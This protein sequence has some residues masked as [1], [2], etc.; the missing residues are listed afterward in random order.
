MTGCHNHRL[1]PV[2]EPAAIDRTGAADLLPSEVG[3]LLDRYHDCWKVIIVVDK[4]NSLTA[5]PDR[6]P[7]ET[8]QIDTSWADHLVTPMPGVPQR[9]L[10]EY[11]AHGGRRCLGDRDMPRGLYRFIRRNLTQGVMVFNSGATC[12]AP[13]GGGGASSRGLNAVDSNCKGQAAS[14]MKSIR[15]A[16]P[17]CRTPDRRRPDAPGAEGEQSP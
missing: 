17:V 16:A 6:L 4:T 8:M 9:I 10:R 2:Y 1:I 15:Q 7:S 14:E 13:R 11:K 5:I 12:P 3:K